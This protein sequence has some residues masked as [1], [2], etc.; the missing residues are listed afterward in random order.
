MPFAVNDDGVPLDN[1]GEVKIRIIVPE[2]FVGASQQ[3]LTARQGLITGM[4]AQ[5]HSVV[6]YASLPG[7][8]YDG[9]V[10]AIVANTQGRGRVALAEG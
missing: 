1:V 5:E 10:E 9:L 7:E 2:E 4:E 3:D 8:K 6:I